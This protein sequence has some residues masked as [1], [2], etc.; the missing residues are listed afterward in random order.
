MTPRRIG[1]CLLI[2]FIGTFTTSTIV[3]SLKE[4]S[5]AMVFLYGAEREQSEEKHTSALILPKII[6][7]PLGDSNE[8]VDVIEIAGASSGAELLMEVTFSPDTD[9]VAS[10]AGGAILLDLDQNSST[11][12]SATEI[13]FG[14]STQDV[15]CEF[16][17]SLYP[18]HVEVREAEM[19]TIVATLPVTQTANALS[20]S[21][22]LSLL[23][24]DE[25]QINVVAIIGD[26]DGP[27]D[28][29]PEVGYGTITGS[30]LHF[31][32]VIMKPE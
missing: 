31:I 1:L 18:D 9:I 2:A 4:N 14:L 7:D 10:E 19:S 22:P 16:L 6:T 25:G 20:F 11:G 32:P 12:K 8:Q 21:V 5:E 27:T 24:N 26:K 3:N 29:A 28:W 13:W 15:G 30:Y 17:L 23:N